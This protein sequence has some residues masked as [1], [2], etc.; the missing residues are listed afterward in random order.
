MK[1]SKP[2]VQAHDYYAT[3]IHRIYHLMDTRGW[4]IRTLSERSS[5]PYDTLTKLLNKKITSTS[6]HNILKIA[7]ALDC[8]VDFLMGLDSSA[9][10]E[11]DLSLHSR[12]AMR[13]IKEL[14]I[15]LSRCRPRHKEDFIPIYSPV[16]L[17][18]E[19]RPAYHLQADL[20]E[21]SRYRSR[22]AERLSYGIRITN[23]LY[24]P[25]FY[26]QDILLIGQERMPRN[27]EMGVFSHHGYL[28][29]RKFFSHA[30]QV[31]LEPINGI[32]PSIILPNLEDWSILGYVLDVHRNLR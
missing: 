1:K 17:H 6:M 5:I 30:E 12:F 23:S 2:G 28:Y 21:I 20:L 13:Y 24:H 16:S 29:I 8:R 32:G 31:L 7:S 3:V 26:E 27:G 15:S 18:S 4:S 11:D 19:E 14:D 22:H 25:V 9:P 10:V